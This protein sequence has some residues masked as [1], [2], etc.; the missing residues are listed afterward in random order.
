[1]DVGGSYA[2]SIGAGRICIVLDRLFGVC[3]EGGALEAVG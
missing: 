2:S 3:W 1:M